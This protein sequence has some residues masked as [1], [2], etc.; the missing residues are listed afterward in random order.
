MEVAGL[1]KTHAELKKRLQI[2][3]DFWPKIALK[4]RKKAYKN[5]EGT[6][7]ASWTVFGDAFLATW[8]ILVDFL[9]PA[10]PK[11]AQNHKDGP[12]VLGS[13]NQQNS[14]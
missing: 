10:G 9:A 7:I 8:S 4:L 2:F 5:S 1:K 13:K 6:K 3:I 12:N 14:L 11:S